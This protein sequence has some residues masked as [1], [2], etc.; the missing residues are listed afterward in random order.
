MDTSTAQA[1]AAITEDSLSGAVE[2]A[3]RS[4]AVLQ[5]VALTDSSDHLD[6][7]RAR[8][9]EVGWILISAHPTMAPLVNL[10]NAVLWSLDDRGE[11]V[12]ARQVV[13][14]V[15]IEFTRRLH[16][17][18]AAIAETT[19]RL[20][21]DEGT[22]L[23]A[24]RSTTVG[25]ALRYAHRAGRRFRVLCAEGRPGLEGRSL[26]TELATSSIPVTL[27]VDALAIASVAEAQLILVGADHLSGI[28]LVNKVGTYGIALAAQ[29]ARVPVY[30][31]CGSEK[32]LPPGYLPP[33]QTEWPAEQVWP[34]APLGVTVA[35]LYFDRTPLATL[36]GIVTE[37]GIQPTAGIEAWLAATRLHPALL[38]GP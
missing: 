15:V 31:L 34:E 24:G 28:G 17:H 25:A 35:N 6:T 4:A 11:L 22:I 13:A 30:A 23:T 10:V 32:F 16:V 5:Q 3:A 19:L 8:L 7:L 26:A 38:A 2:I 21:P 14:E 27:M 36:A 29:V 20:I 1:I 33:A 37:Q 18:E 12:Q 9:L